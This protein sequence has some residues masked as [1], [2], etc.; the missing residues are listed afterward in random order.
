MSKN[1]IKEIKCIGLRSWVW[2]V[3]RLKRNEYHTSLDDN[4]DSRH[5]AHEIDLKLADLNT[6]R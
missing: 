4:Y 2:F 1:F 3:F 5:R 6:K